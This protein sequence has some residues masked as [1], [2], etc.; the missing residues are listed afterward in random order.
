[1]KIDL[2]VGLEIGLEIGLILGNASV[3]GRRP[4]PMVQVRR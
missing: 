1:M 4:A 3:D 2:K